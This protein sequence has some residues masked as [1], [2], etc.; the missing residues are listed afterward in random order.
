MFCS[1]QWEFCCK[2]LCLLVEYQTAAFMQV[3][4]EMI[5]LHAHAVDIILQEYK[6][7]SKWQRVSQQGQILPLAP[8]HLGHGALRRLELGSGATR[9]FCP[10]LHVGIWPQ[11]SLHASFGSVGSPMAHGPAFSFRPT[12]RCWV[13]SWHVGPQSLIPA[14]WARQTWQRLWTGS[15]ALTWPV[16]ALYYIII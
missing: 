9:C 4:A 10:A 16:C 13:R 2:T 3:Q 14:H 5:I 12:G 8:C 11:T 7:K 1:N 15:V 6:F